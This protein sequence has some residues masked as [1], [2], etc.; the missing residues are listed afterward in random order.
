MFSPFSAMWAVDLSYVDFI[1]LTYILP[2]P[3][4]FMTFVMNGYLIWSK[5]FYALTKLIV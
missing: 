5:A 3:S 1:I 2:I 4:F